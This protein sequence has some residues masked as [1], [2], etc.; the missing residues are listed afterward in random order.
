MWCQIYFGLWIFLGDPIFM[1][2][3]WESKIYSLYMWSLVPHQ[4]LII[5]R[6]CLYTSS[7]LYVLVRKKWEQR[8]LLNTRAHGTSRSRR[9]G[10]GACAILTQFSFILTFFFFLL[11]LTNVGKGLLGLPKSFALDWRV[12]F[13][14]GLY[15][16]RA[17]VV[18]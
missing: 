6:R 16:C 12:G 1:N 4:K 11:Y 13:F 5:C 17:R 14:F 7:L 9:A 3:V 8:L 10:G 2:F 15:I 18:G